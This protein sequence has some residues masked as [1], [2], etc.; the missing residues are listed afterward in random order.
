MR[1][2]YRADPETMAA[3]AVQM[4]DAGARIVG[5]CCGSSPDHLRAMHDALIPATH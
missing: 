4:R 5:A 2:V 1:A 3:F